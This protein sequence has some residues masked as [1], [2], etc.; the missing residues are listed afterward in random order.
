MNEK[1]IKEA[2]LIKI[3]ILEK[4]N[5][6]YYDRNS[7]KISDAEYDDLKKD[8]INLEKK[9]KFLSHKSSPSKVV[10]FKYQR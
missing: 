8:I 7:P 5:E 1:K 6:S 9:Y 10:G 4:H 2:Y 3:K